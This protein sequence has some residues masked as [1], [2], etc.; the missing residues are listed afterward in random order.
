MSEGRP[1][2]WVG[3]RE[4]PLGLPRACIRM[5]A[6]QL[7]QGRGAPKSFVWW[8]SR[9]AE[10]PRHMFVPCPEAPPSLYALGRSAAGLLAARLGSGL[11]KQA[12]LGRRAAA[13]VRYADC[14]CHRE[15]QERG[16]G[17]QQDAQ[18]LARGREDRTRAHQL[19]HLPIVRVWGRAEPGSCGVGECGWEEEGLARK[20]GCTRS[21]RRASFHAC[22]AAFQA[23]VD[24]ARTCSS[25]P[26]LTKSMVL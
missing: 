25:T 23:R 24:A 4:G 11:V 22:S 7:A 3:R 21:R 5:R 20:S 16:R 9:G 1:A 17:G 26:T 18:C 8:G 13:E 15:R 10:P 19:P 14:I 2:P 6:V 12:S